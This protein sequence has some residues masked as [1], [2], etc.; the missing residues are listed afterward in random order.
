MSEAIQPT[1]EPGRTRERPIRVAVVD[2]HGLVREGLRLIL[3]TATDVEVVGE[4][5]DVGEVFE[6]IERS[7]PAVV[8]LDISLGAADAI[9]LLRELGARFPA[10][11]AVVVTMHDDAETVRQALLAG[12]AGYV[13]KGARGDELL[14]A[15]RAVARGERYIHSAV[16]GAVVADSLRWLRQGARLSPRE[17]DVVRL[18]TDGLTAREVGKTLGISAHTVRRHVANVATKLEV[19]G[20]AGIARYAFEHGLIRSNR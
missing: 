18:V 6:M 14:A 5:G 16:A 20:R 11:R 2:D 4:A 1:V 8:L 19:R 3:G 12:A 9:P 15:V 13:V 17:R 10:A 7:A